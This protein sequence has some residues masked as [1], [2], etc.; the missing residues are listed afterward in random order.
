MVSGAGV[1]PF[2]VELAPT[3]D[4]DLVV[5]A[6]AAALGV[7]EQ[8]HRRIMDSVLDTIGAPRAAAAG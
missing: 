7:A 8:P 1:S 2:L 5:P 3:S 6:V 4:G